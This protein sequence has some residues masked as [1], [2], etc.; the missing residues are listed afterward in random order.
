MKFTN[1]MEKMIKDSL[2][3]FY[4]VADIEF[5]IDEY[6]EESGYLYVEEQ[7]PCDEIIRTIIKLNI[8]NEDYKIIYY[9]YKHSDDNFVEVIAEE[10]SDTYNKYVSLYKSL[11]AILSN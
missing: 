10:T 3:D 11:D 9:L 8:E 4:I 1:E 2:N 7:V 6:D 5:G